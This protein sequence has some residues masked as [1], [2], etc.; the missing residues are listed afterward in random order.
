MNSSLN[1]QYVFRGD[2]KP[3]CYIPIGEALG[4]IAHLRLSKRQQKHSTV[5][6]ELYCIKV[7]Y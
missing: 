6:H 7:E 5:V 4:R 3:I 2:L 1:E